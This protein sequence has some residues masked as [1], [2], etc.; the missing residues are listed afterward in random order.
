MPRNKLVKTVSKKFKCIIFPFCLLSDTICAKPSCQ[1]ANKGLDVLTL[2]EEQNKDARIE[3]DTGVEI[4]SGNWALTSADKT[5]RR[6]GRGD[7]NHWVDQ[8]IQKHGCAGRHV[9]TSANKP[10]ACCH[11]GSYFIHF[12]FS[13]VRLCSVT[14]NK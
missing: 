8:E 11:V 10:H 4:D 6:K 13:F 7:M 5:D 3:L 1:L 9:P 2:C 12:C 14:E